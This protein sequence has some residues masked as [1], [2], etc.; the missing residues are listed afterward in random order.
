[1][2]QFCASLTAMRWPKEAQLSETKRKKKKKKRQHKQLPQLEIRKL[3]LQHLR[4]LLA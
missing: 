3:Q 1:M 2:Q 4:F